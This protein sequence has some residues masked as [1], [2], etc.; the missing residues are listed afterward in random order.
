MRDTRKIAAIIGENGFVENY[1]VERLVKKGFVVRLAT[2]SPEH[3]KNQKIFGAVGQVVSLFYSVDQENTLVRAIEGATVVINLIDAPLGKRITQLEKLNVTTAKTIARICAAAGVEKLLHFSALGAD[4]Q[5]PSP[6]LVSKKKGEEVVQAVN[7]SAIIVRSGIPFGPEDQ[8]LNKIAM[9]AT[10]FPIM[11]VYHVNTRLQP[12]YVGDV[13]DAVMKIIDL[14]TVSG[15]VFELA[16]PDVY[17][18]RKLVVDLIQWLHRK[19][20]ISGLFPG[21]IRFMAFFLQFMPGSIMTLRLINSM[22]Y[23][24]VAVK[25]KEVKGLQDLGIVPTSIKMMA[26]VYLYCYR[27]AC[28]FKV[29]EKLQK[30]AGDQ[31][32]S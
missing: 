9:M 32:I 26:P 29:L 12:V 7:P 27:P 31:I 10:Y 17:T 22:R 8:F 30:Q 5:S 13:A 3:V 25:G 19:N 1:L 2:S 6:Y 11:P 20:D 4:L 16:G 21:F 28:D 15:T 14:A 18:N 24:S 23:D